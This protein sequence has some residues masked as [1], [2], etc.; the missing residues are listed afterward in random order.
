MLNGG[1]L[2]DARV[3]SRSAVALMTSDPLGDRGG[4]SRVYYRREIKQLVYPAIVD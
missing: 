3:L 4:P 2:N 1:K